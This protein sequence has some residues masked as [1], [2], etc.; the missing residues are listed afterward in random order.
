MGV[1]ARVQIGAANAAGQ[2]L[3]QHLPRGRFGLGQRI[4][5]DLAVP[6]N[7]SA[8][9]TSSLRYVIVL[10]PRR[11]PGVTRDAAL[12]TASAEMKWLNGFSLAATF[13]G[14]FSGTTASYAGKGVVRYAW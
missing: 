5:D 2:R 4:D 11:L 7:G 8:Q 6:E 1:L 13:E 3:D 9:S 14:E 10:I 12:T